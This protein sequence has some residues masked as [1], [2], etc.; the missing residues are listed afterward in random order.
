MGVEGLE[1]E[2]E[3]GED[4]GG[5]GGVHRLGGAAGCRSGEFGCI[6]SPVQGKRP[7][8]SLCQQ[9]RAVSQSQVSIVLSP[10]ELDL[11][12]S[13]FVPAGSELILSR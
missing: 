6:G 12:H 1:R 2:W 9:G 7:G 13:W 5:G 11:R 4:H 10:S 8:A 3:N